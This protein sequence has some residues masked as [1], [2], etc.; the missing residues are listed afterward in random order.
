[1]TQSNELLPCPFC[2]SSEIEYHYNTHAH[3]LSCENCECEVGTEL[4]FADA[5]TRW[6]T[7][8][9]LT[10]PQS[11]N[12]AVL[13]ALILSLKHMEEYEVLIDGEM[14]LSRSLET[15][16]NDGDLPVVIIKAR[17]AIAAATQADEPIDLDSL[18]KDTSNTQELLAKCEDFTVGYNT[19][20]N[21]CIEHLKRQKGR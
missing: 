5:K 19:G 9:A 2:G 17:E 20:W 3:W 21:A 13:D 6:N 16:E 14:G 1:M 18:K 10:P 4:T 8:H 11:P 15:L 12:R 7:R